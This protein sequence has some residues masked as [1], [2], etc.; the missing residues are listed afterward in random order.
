MAVAPGELW[1]VSVP[2]E[3]TAQEAWD[4]LNRGTAS[5][6]VNSKFTIPDLKVGEGGNMHSFG[7]ENGALFRYGRKFTCCSKSAFTF[8]NHPPSRETRTT[9]VL[10]QVGT[11]DQLVGLSDDL[12]K[13]DG[14][15]EA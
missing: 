5:L 15:A 9:T 1:L 4:R 7:S 8:I 3:K 12:A 2:G 6:A 11:L 10:F 13:L 14:A